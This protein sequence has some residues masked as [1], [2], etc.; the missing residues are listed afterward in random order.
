MRSPTRSAHRRC[1]MHWRDLNSRSPWKRKQKRN[2]CD[3][4]G[5]GA[6]AACYTDAAKMLDFFRQ[7]GL[8]NVIY[9]AVIVATILAVVITFRPNA[10]SRTAS[11]TE[12]CAARVRGRCIDP[13][14]FGAAYRILMPSRS[15]SL[16]R[17]MNLKRVALDRLIERELLDDEGKR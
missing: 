10:T 1:T 9:G 5:A 2:L 14:D 12:A 13:K 16:S 8:S 17:K 11:L 4:G 6:V 15:G 7:R 3:R